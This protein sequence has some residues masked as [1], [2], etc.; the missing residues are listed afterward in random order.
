MCY[1][2]NLLYVY[3]YRY[4]RDGL[5]FPL[6]YLD[7]SVPNLPEVIRESASLRSSAALSVSADPCP[8]LSSVM[9]LGAL[10]S[11]YST[12]APYASAMAPSIRRQSISCACTTAGNIERPRSLP[13]PTLHHDLTTAA[14]CTRS[15]CAADGSPRPE[16]IP[17]SSGAERL[18]TVRT[19]HERRCDTVNTLLMFTVPQA[20]AHDVHWLWQESVT[21]SAMHEGCSLGNTQK[22]SP[23]QSRWAGVPNPAASSVSP[24]LHCSYQAWMAC[25]TPNQAGAPA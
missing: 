10:S 12:T 8:Q 19:I 18:S 5:I 17:N 25:T 14:A 1:N 21:L 6:S 9:T 7:V 2:D 23:S 16:Q 13:A 24:H 3:I 4:L 22:P 15:P 20:A 11:G